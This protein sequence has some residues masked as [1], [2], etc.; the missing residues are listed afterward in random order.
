M[1]NILITV[2]VIT[3]TMTA[4]SII[5]APLC[6]IHTLPLDLDHKHNIANPHGENDYHIDKVTNQL[7]VLSHEIKHT[8]PSKIS[9]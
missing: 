1:F 7:F 6:Q 4:L 8:N 9:R 2:F 5:L 3:T